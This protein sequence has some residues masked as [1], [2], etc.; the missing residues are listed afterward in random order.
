MTTEI[1]VL[2]AD[3]HPIVRNGLRQA[4]EADAHLKVVAETGDGETTRQAL[5]ELQPDVAVLD[6]YMPEVSGFGPPQAIAFDLVRA[7][8]HQ[9]LAT[10]VILLTSQP[11]PEW[12]TVARKLD[13]KGYVLKDSAIVEI[14]QSVKTV[15]AG[16]H[17]YSPHLSGQLAHQQSI[18]EQF[19]Q[20]YPGL[21]ELTPRE[22]EV[23]RLI[24]TGQSS[25]EIAT[26]LRIGAPAV[27]NHRNHICQKLMLEGSMTLLR[28]VLAHKEEVLRFCEDT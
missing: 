23:L 28:F 2:I 8:Q 13:V 25:E 22:K 7:M 16:Y 9:Q 14:I 24:P 10:R 6:I 3:D 4:I 20:Q 21:K 1:R 26:A 27:N 5:Q 17:Y 15:A 18:V 19:L 12:L 11:E